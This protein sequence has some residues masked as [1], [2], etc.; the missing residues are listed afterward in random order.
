[1][2][3]PVELPLGA[4][5]ASHAA[6]GLPRRKLLA[7]RVL[8]FFGIIIVAVNLRTAVAS[9][10]P[11]IVTLR[12]EMGVSGLELAALGMIPP[13]CYA[14]FGVLTPRISRR[15]GLELTLLGALVALVVGLSG[16]PLV[17]NATELL[18]WS[19]LLFA[20]MGMGNV[21]LPPLVKKY[22]PDRIGLM[23]T[24]YA[25]MFAIGSL[26][27]PLLAVP[28]AEAFGWRTSLGVWALISLTSFLP[29][30]A[31]LASR[32]A[33]GEA[34]RE[35]SP[36]A[37][38]SP[39]RSPMAWAIMGLFI[40]SGANAYSLFA[41][42]PTLLFDSAGISSGTSG[43]L[44]SVYASLGFPTSLLIPLVIARFNAVR[45]LVALAA[46]SYV[47]GYAGLIFAPGTL[48]WLWVLCAGLGPM[49]FAI[50]LV[51]INL[52]TR[53]QS[54]ATAVSGFVQGIGYGFVAVATFVF[55]L[56]HALSGGWSAPL[57]FLLALTLALLVP[58][59]LLAARKRFI[60]DGN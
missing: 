13:L 30:L 17:A 2:T 5:T 7:G 8:A 9:L 6:V 60:E 19:V 32:R 58:S 55:G 48:T 38:F 3:G 42:L 52:R 37:R 43:A 51:L 25:T 24:L 20:G 44:L 33:A 12:E 39:W 40:A 41:W 49:T 29:W 35:E 57:I 53:T 59:A 46:A 34:L 56:V 36:A 11:L 16:R 45:S 23:T 50:S 31:L 4:D 27:P 10:S 15:L 26:T 54:G 18:A 47:L 22:F 1:M 14:V 28:M 21:L